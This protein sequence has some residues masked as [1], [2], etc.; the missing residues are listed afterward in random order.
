[1]LCHHSPKP[2]RPHLLQQSK[3]SGVLAKRMLTIL[4]SSY[5]VLLPYQQDVIESASVC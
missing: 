1:V 4:L 3:G 5:L 2:V